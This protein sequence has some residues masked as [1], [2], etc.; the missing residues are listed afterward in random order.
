MSMS[1]TASNTIVIFSVS[2]PQ[3]KW[4]YTVLFSSE[5]LNVQVN[6]SSLEFLHTNFGPSKF[7]ISYL[8]HFTSENKAF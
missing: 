5:M 1:V 2:V 6:S 3:M 7:S 4:E 8:A